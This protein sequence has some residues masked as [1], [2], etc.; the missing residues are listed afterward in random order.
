MCCEIFH[1]G[2]RMLSM[3]SVHFGRGR[4]F[5][6]PTVVQSRP[7]DSVIAIGAFCRKEREKEKWAYRAVCYS[8]LPVL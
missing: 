4:R 7:N 1:F 3:R 5:Y 2:M 6:N 8:F